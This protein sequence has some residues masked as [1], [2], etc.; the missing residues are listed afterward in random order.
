MLARIF[1]SALLTLVLVVALPSVTFAQDVSA[2]ISSR[3]A[4]V[5]S[6]IVLQIQIRNAENYSLPEGFEIDGCDV[7]SAGT[8]SQSSQITI[9]NG[10]RSESRSVAAQYL[11]CP[12]REGE[13]EIPPFEINVDGK[14]KKTQPM[15]FV[16]TKSETGDLLFVEVEGKKESVYVGQQLDLKL[17]IWIKPFSD[18]DKNI[19]LNEGHMWQ[20]LSEQSSWGAFT[21]RMK[22]LAE[23]RQRPGGK[24]V[25]R[26]D[27]EGRSR[28]YFLYEIEGKVYPTKPGKLDASDLQ[29][30][31][32]YPLSLGRRR[33]PFDS[34][35]DDSSLMKQVMGDDFFSSSP[36]GRRLTVT[37]SRPVVADANVNSTEVMPIPTENR[38]ADY[39]GAVGKYQIVAEAEPKNV[40]AGDPITLRLGI[41]GDGPMEVVQAP[42]LHDI[43][44]LASDFQVSDQSLAGFVQ[45]DSKVFITTIRPRSESVT[46]IPAIPFSFFD[47]D[48]KAYQTVYTQPIDIEV[49]RAEALQLDSIVSNSPQGSVPSDS[50]QTSANNASTAGMFLQNDF[51]ENVLLPESTM[52]RNGWLYFAAIPAGCWLLLLTAKLATVFPTAIGK[53]KS[54]VAQARNAINSAKSGEALAV[55]LR[56]FVSA[57]VRDN[58]PTNEHAVGRIRALGDYETA[59][60]LESLF[61]QIGRIDQSTASYSE[62][63]SPLSIDDLRG[64]CHQMLSDIEKVSKHRRWS[65]VPAS[66]STKR[67]LTATMVMFALSGLA[68]PQTVSAEDISLSPLLM[69]ANESYRKASEMADTDLAKSRDMFRDAAGNYQRLVD[70]GVRNSELFFNLGNAWHQSDQPAKAI[71]NYHRALTLNPGMQKASRNLELLKQELSI[72]DNRSVES[73]QATW[74]SLDRAKRMLSTCQQWLGWSMTTFLFAVASIVFWGLLC[75][76]TIR[77]KTPVLRWAMVPFVLMSVTGLSLYWSQLEPANLAIVTS[78]TIELRRSDGNEFPVEAELDPSLG[79]EVKITNEREGWFEIALPNGKSGW[80]SAQNVEPI[81]L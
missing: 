47:P 8:P 48:K 41:V 13:F 39:R 18:R 55:A 24:A 62:T 34:I 68:I 1:N 63:E 5:G 33:D 52:A 45:D 36:F 25:L 28:Q 80:T 79:T 57:S 60:S 40:V 71:V 56:N 3:E 42:P 14:T 9:I 11:I 67:N 66:R 58:C 29:I 7:Q 75:L 20:M 21:D 53:L 72:A 46:Q 10:R 76:K 22:E 59:N 17:K 2:Q 37:E 73:N 50:S 81:A 70:Q 15:R 77:R 26:K 23:N 27:E 61:H 49:E 31:I 44:N 16:A 30:V 38:P 12:K 43:E 51:S 6:P 65:K 69:K 78:D 19:K 4:W 35:F 32:D 54:P 74:L 64:E